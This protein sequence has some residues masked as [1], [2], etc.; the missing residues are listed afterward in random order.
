MRSTRG[1]AAS[2]AGLLTYPAAI[3]AGILIGGTAADTVVHFV[4]G[5]AFILLALAMFDF[6]LARW[7]TW[8]GAAA[9]VVFGGTFVLQGITDLTHN[10]SLEWLAF[11]ILGQQLERVLPDVVYIWFAALLLSGTAGATRFVG[12]VI[13]PV[14][15]GLELA[16]VLGTVIGVAVPFTILTIFLPFTWLLLESVKS[17]SGMGAAIRQMAG[18]EALSA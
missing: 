10:P 9:A 11:D 2:I 1:L 18:R 15:Y 3:A 7:V 5:T 17:R 13:V 6:G 12:W 4:L 8:L 14:F 16:I